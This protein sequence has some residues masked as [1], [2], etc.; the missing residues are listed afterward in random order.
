MTWRIA[1]R[2]GRG[3]RLLYALAGRRMRR[4]LEANLAALTAFVEQPATQGVAK[5]SK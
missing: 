3:Q 2:G 5:R 4:V 1:L